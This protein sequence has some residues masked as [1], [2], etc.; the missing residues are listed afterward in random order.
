[1]YAERGPDEFQISAGFDQ[2]IDSKAKRH[3]T[4]SDTLVDFKPPR[5]SRR[6]W[7]IAF[8]A[9]FALVLFEFLPVTLR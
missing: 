5:K 4:N 1:M 8:S 9:L 3:R 6:F 7:G 2:K